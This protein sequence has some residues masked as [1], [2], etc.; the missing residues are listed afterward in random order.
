MIPKLQRED[1]QLNILLKWQVRSRDKIHHKKIQSA[2]RTTPF[3]KLIGF[4]IP[5]NLPS[6]HPS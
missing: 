5:S 1:G 6:D 4:G 3:R 2:D